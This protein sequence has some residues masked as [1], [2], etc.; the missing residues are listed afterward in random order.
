MG[1]VGEPAP[2]LPARFALP[3]HAHQLYLRIVDQGGALAADL[4]GP[5]EEEPLRRLAELKLVVYEP[6]DARWVATDPRQLQA[7][8]A[9]Q[10][11]AEAVG[12]L[13]LASVVPA[14][15]EELAA[16]YSRHSRHRAPQRDSVQ[17][18]HGVGA[19]RSRIAALT[20]TVREE[21]LTV[22]PGRRPPRFL[23]PGPTQREIDL[24]R[25]GV[26]RR[27]IYEARV[28][29]EPAVR[30]YARTV[31]R[32]G[33]QLRTL[34][35]PVG[36]MFVLDRRTAVIP[37]HGNDPE[38]AAF[39]TEPTA[40]AFLVSCFERDWARADPFDD[41][42]PPRVDQL[43]EAQHAV[44]RLLSEGLSQPSMARRLALSERTV[45][46]LVAGIRTRFGAA[47]LF[48]LGLAI[49]REQS[50]QGEATREDPTG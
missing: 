34:D 38:I 14:Q 4:V 7:S 18:V 19:V 24:A 2:G 6:I 35:E 20:E 15:V 28:R 39:I 3:E 22:Q 12:A 29:R 42:E 32:S 13:S 10:L 49:G 33:V 17:Y 44:V 47:T 36:R 45:A 43:S 31:S 5:G 50:R 26:Q 25:A 9:M 30:E 41:F 27:T 40:V 48:Q 23:A 8:W 46:N 16:L 1:T 11:H 21:F 37:L